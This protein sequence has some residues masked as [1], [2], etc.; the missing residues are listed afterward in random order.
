MRERKKHK[1]RSESSYG[2][3]DIKDALKQLTEEVRRSGVGRSGKVNHRG[4]PV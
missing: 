2:D 3:D 1:E 4:E